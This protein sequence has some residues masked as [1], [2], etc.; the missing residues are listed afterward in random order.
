MNNFELKDH[1]TRFYSKLHKYITNLTDS[2]LFDRC[3]IIIIILNTIQMSLET[4]FSSIFSDFLLRLSHFFTILY[5]IEFPLKI[6]AKPYL[7][8][9]SWSNMFDFLNL[10][11][12]YFD[13][14]IDIFGFMKNGQKSSFSGFFRTTRSLKVFRT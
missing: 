10:F 11:F 8:F 1:I 9:K 13:W 7:Y 4:P 2:K 14:S 6:Y 5:T 12:A 3:I